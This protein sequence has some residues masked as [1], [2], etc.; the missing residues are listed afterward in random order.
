MAAERGRTSG[1]G[2]RDRLRQAAGSR[3]TER[4]FGAA[5][6]TDLSALRERLVE[7]V[8]P[9]VRSTG[10]E[11]DGLTVNR[12]GR[13][14]LVRVVVDGDNGVDSGVIALLAR[15][16]SAALD[17]AEQAHGEMV[18]GQY[19]LEVSSPGVDRPLTEPRHWRRNLGRLVKVKMGERTVTGRVVGV[20][21][22]A[23]SL[24][25]AGTVHRAEYA[26]LGPGRVEVEF[27]RGGAAPAG[28][29]DDDLNDADL[30]DDG[31]PD[32]DEEGVDEE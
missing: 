27:T 31:D 30:Y 24:D 14:H 5:T 15:D 19:T 17:A 20:D 6:R 13:R 32:E 18:A 7:V 28:G 25:V 26:G 22:E 9:A 21:D 23:V 10:Y 12:V 2:G 3:R 1:S 16:I 8:E 11:L 29:E 4:P